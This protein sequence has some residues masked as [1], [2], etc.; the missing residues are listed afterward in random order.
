MLFASPPALLAYRKHFH[1]LGSRAHVVL[2]RR[3]DAALLDVFA[4]EMS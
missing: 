4:L 3:S 2:I 1:H